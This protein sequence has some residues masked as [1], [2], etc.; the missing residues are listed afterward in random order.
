MSGEMEPHDGN[1][2]AGGSHH[3]YPDN[4]VA[5]ENPYLY[6]LATVTVYDTQ[7]GRELAGANSVAPVSPEMHCDNC[8][9]DNGPGNEAFATSVVSRT[10]FHST[11]RSTLPTIPITTA[12]G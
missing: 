1:F 4:D 2:V 7:T 11:M 3:Q 12:A 8:N 5:L 9:H 10:S 6:Q